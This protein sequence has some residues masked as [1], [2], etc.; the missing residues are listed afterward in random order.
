MNNLPRLT[1]RLSIR[2]TNLLRAIDNQQFKSSERC[3]SLSERLN[4]FQADNWEKGKSQF[5]TPK[6]WPL[7][8]EIIREPVPIDAATKPRAVYYHFRDNIK[9]SPKKMW[10][11]CSFVRGLTVDEAVKQLS[12]ITTKGAHIAKEVILEGQQKAIQNG[13]EFKS[14]M[15]IGECF[16][17]KGLVLRGQRKHA[18]Y[19]IGEIRYFYV[20][21]YVKLVEGPPPKAYYYDPNPKTGKDKIKKFIEDHRAKK[22][23]WTL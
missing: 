5:P 6:R 9:Y 23:E 15:H 22:I 16:C 12:F 2:S 18:R 4:T 1:S 20:H 21:F 10:Y 17:T 11:I 3:L 19:R 14:N 8:N 7:Y 13:F